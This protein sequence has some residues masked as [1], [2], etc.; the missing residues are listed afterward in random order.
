MIR[1]GPGLGGLTRGPCVCGDTVVLGPWARGGGALSA[2]AGGSAGPP[3]PSQHAFAHVLALGW[4]RREAG[5][6]AEFEAWAQA[7]V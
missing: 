6:G 1:K 2:V 3:R 4:G 5:G 7:F